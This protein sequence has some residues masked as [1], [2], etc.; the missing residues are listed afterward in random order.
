MCHCAQ[1]ISVSLVFHGLLLRF[2]PVDQ[3]CAM[4]LD[5]IDPAKW[6]LLEDAT[7]EYIHSMAHKFDD[8]AA[9]LSKV[10]DAWLT[11]SLF[12]SCDF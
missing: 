5:E 7:R 6:A 12:A 9:A 2:T 4:E 10:W 11:R 3:R 1:Y 8:V